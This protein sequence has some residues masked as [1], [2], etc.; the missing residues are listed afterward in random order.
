MAKAV[1]TWNANTE[2][3]LAGY[4]VWRGLGTAAPTL[5]VTLGKVTTYTD[6][7]VP[8]VD[9]TV[10]YA[11]KAFDTAGNRSPISV[12]VSKVVNAVP[13]QAPTGLSVVIE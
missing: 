9:Q 4:E 1:L 6:T 13:P 11:L 7:T 3:D 2:A 10:T 12:P 8:D 5:L